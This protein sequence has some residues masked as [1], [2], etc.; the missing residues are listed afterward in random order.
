M[1]SAVPVDTILSLITGVAPENTVTTATQ[2]MTNMTSKE[3]FCYQVLNALEC[4]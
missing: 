3:E 4:Q 1:E 2:T